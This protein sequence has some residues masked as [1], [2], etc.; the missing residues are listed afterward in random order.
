MHHSQ[1]AALLANQRSGCPTR[2]HSLTPP[3]PP[4]RCCLR[5]YA[6]VE[7][8]GKVQRLRKQCPN[9][10]P[11]TFM[12]THYDRVYCGKCG[13]TFVY[14]GK[15]PGAPPP[16]KPKAVVE[17]AAPVKGGGKKGKK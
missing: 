4:P 1:K 9:C 7:D 3:A 15:A 8:S 14:E 5:G 2:L 12:A 16:P 11:G 6:Q 13:S 17:E 10:G